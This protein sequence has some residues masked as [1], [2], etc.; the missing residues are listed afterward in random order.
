[1]QISAEHA[2]LVG[3]RQMVSSTSRCCSLCVPTFCPIEMQ[4]RILNLPNA[5]I[6]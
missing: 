5:I 4:E 1:M 6:V 2:A 3:V